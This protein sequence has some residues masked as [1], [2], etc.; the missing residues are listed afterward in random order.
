MTHT[1]WQI[2]LTAEATS[3]QELINLLHQITTRLETKGYE[4]YYGTQTTVK[5]DNTYADYNI[6]PIINN[7]H[8]EREHYT[9][10]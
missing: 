1:P 10:R 4:P 9:E 3:Y 5:N 8:Q 7:N 6:Q 2:E